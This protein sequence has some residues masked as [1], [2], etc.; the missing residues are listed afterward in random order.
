MQHDSCADPG[1]SPGFGSVS[2]FWK[3]SSKPGLATMLG[4]QSRFL[5][6]ICEDIYS[7]HYFFSLRMDSYPFTDGA[8]NF[9]ESL[10]VLIVVI[11]LLSLRHGARQDEKRRSLQYPLTAGGQKCT[12]PKNLSRNAARRKARIG[13]ITFTRWPCWPIWQIWRIWG[14]WRERKNTIMCK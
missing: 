6:P 1:P 11:Y 13:P 12:L 14:I 4:L 10:P 9:Q 2:A 3:R 5:W 8:Q 7:L